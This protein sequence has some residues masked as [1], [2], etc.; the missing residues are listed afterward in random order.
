MKKAIH[1]ILLLLF[2]SNSIFANEGM[3]I[4]SLLKKLNEQ[5]LKSRGLKIGVEQIWSTD[6]A[7]IKDAIVQFGGG[8]TAEVISYKG[9][10]LTNH[11]C[12]FSQIQAHSTLE[13]DYLKNGFWAMDF[14]QELPNPGL[15]AM[16]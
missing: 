10:L 14:S 6:K 2:T 5:E 13:N 15:T 1:L 9:L 16:F 4:P 3:W 11:H 7:S 8:C 12:G